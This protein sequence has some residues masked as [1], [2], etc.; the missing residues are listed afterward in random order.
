MLAEL[1]GG[2]WPLYAFR[3]CDVGRTV[4]WTVGAVCLPR[5]WCWQNC[6]VDCRRCAFPYCDV[7]KTGGW[8]VGAVCLSRLWCSLTKPGVYSRLSNLIRPLSF[9]LSHHLLTRTHCRCRGHCCT[10]S[11]WHTHTH[12]VGLL[13]MRDRPVATISTSQHAALTFDRHPCLRRNSN[14]QSQQT[15]VRRPRPWPTRPR[16][17][18][19]DYA[20]SDVCVHVLRIQCFMWHGF[21]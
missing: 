13:W 1:A 9:D 10:R 12:S 15:S 3:D 16:R 11:Q 5:L 2:L 20:L 4:R 17:P 21:A 6:T 7:G 8:T 19:S 18:V 14:P